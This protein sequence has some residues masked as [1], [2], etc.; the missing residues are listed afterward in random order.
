MNWQDAGIV[1]QASNYSDSV[2][3]LT[4]LTR[5]HGL[6]KGSCSKQDLVHASVGNIVNVG[7]RG[8]LEEH[9]GRFTISNFEPI[10]PRF[11]NDRERILALSSICSLFAK[12]LNEHEPQEHLYSALEELL[13]AMVGNDPGWKRKFC[14]A[15][16]ELLAA[17]GFGL[18]LSQCAV[19]RST[20]DLAYVSPRSGKAVSREV[21]HSYMDKLFKM[22]RALLPLESEYAPSDLMEAMDLIEFFLLRHSQYEGCAVRD[23]VKAMWA[24]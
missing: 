24:K 12:C 4:L 11:Y 23:V 3:V 21:G 18:D 20:H 19:T 17:I 6:R 14:L 7:W 22:P 13:D 9:L 10:Y 16:M 5:S 2:S 1:L 15:E 8:R